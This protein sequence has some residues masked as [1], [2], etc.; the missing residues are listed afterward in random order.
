MEFKV[1]PNE[2]EQRQID[3]LVDVIECGGVGI[4]LEFVK[5]R[6]I[7]YSWGQEYSILVT[8]FMARKKCHYHFNY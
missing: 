4:M 7:A 3:F 2:F 8:S 6:P 5:D 1:A